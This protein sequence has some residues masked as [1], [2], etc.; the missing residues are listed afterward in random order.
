MAEL[1]YYLLWLLVAL[2]VAA[3]ASAGR[4][5]QAHHRPGRQAQARAMLRALSCYA[6]W[7][8]AQY[9]ATAATPAHR[10][11]HAALAQARALQAEAFPELRLPMADLLTAERG[12]ADLLDRTGD[13]PHGQDAGM[14][15]RRERL[16]QAHQGALATLTQWLQEEIDSPAPRTAEPG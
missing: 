9:R 6:A 11:P 10:G 13:P 2:L 4:V 8:A 16:W 1:A 7:G 3:L 12:L 14:P 15:A 5:A